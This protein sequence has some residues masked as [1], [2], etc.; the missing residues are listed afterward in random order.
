MLRQG[1]PPLFIRSNGMGLSGVIFSKAKN[2]KT[3]GKK[4][5]SEPGRNKIWWVYYES[6]GNPTLRPICARRFLDLP[7]VAFLVVGV[8]SLCVRW[9]MDGGVEVLAA[10]DFDDL[11]KSLRPPG[12]PH[13]QEGS[14]ITLILTW[15]M[16]HPLGSMISHMYRYL[17]GACRSWP[18]V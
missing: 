13:P 15:H 10:Q 18:N 1:I 16:P 9:L 17:L 7:P 4:R 14:R 6:G 12:V 5:K 8:P 3:R 11:L 2:P